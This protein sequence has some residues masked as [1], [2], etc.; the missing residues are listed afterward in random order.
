[1][2]LTAVVNGKKYTMPDA[3]K[4]SV[5][6]GVNREVIAFAFPLFG[7]WQLRYAFRSGFTKRGQY[8]HNS[9]L[10]LPEITALYR[11]AKKKGRKP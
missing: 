6:L 9:S 2:K 5:V 4:G 10:T 8:G 1:M 11:A 7:E 3:P